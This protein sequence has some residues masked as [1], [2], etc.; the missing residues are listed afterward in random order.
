MDAIAMLGLA[1]AA[2]NMLGNSSQKQQ[3][4]QLELMKQQKE[5]N[6]E[7]LREQIEGQKELFDYTS[8]GRR[9]QQLKEAGLNPGL[10]YSGGAGG[11][12]VTGSISAPQVSQGPA[13]NVAQSQ[14]TK[15]AAI[16][17]AL[18]LS[19]LQSEIELNKSSAEKLSA[20]AE[21]TKG[22]QTEKTTQETINLQSTKSGIELENNFKKIQNDIAGATTTSQIERITWE[23][24]QV[25]QNTDKIIAE[26]RQSKAEAT[27]TEKSINA[28]IEQNKKQVEL[29]GTQ[30]IKNKSETNLN[31]EQARAVYKNVII[32]FERLK[33]ENQGQA[34]EVSK[35]EADIYRTLLDNNAAMKREWVKALSNLIGAT[36]IRAGL[37]K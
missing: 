27:I 23:A 4:Y 19:K 31:E 35:I 11:G 20:E 21:F 37:G 3:E 32:N 5:Y 9:V 14:Q 7:A 29:I 22:V 34:I 6:T 16:G 18:Q 15:I 12:G 33:L 28:L 36:V 26:T 13:P 2:W 1:N 25:K 17:M 10:I 8:Y 24:E 30:I